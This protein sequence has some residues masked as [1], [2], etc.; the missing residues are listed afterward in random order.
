VHGDLEPGKGNF[1]LRLAGAGAHA[2]CPPLPVRA[3][4]GRPVFA[5]K[6]TACADAFLGFLSFSMTLLLTLV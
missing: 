5:M 1:Q 4:G 3:A 2:A 6:N